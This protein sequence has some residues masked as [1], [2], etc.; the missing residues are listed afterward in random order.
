MT[1]AASVWSGVIP[2]HM[3]QRA[4]W[5][6]WADEPDTGQ[7]KVPFIIGSGAKAKSN[8]PSTWRSFAE[9]LKYHESPRP[10]RTGVGYVFAPDDGLT[11][12][13]FDNCL[14]EGGIVLKAWAKP[15]VTP[16]LGKTYVEVSPSGKGLHVFV[17][18]AGPETGKVVKV[19]DGQ[20]E[21]YTRGR[22]STV[23][24]NVYGAQVH[25]TFPTFSER[26]ENRG[27]GLLDEAQDAVDA[28][29]E[30]LHPKTRRDERQ[31][32]T[33]GREKSTRVDNRYLPSRNFEDRE[34]ICD[35]LDAI[36][37]D[38]DYDRWTKIGM[39]LSAEYERHGTGLALWQSWSARGEK[40]KSG[41]C[42]AKWKSFRRN[43]VNIGTLFHIAKECGWQPH[44]APRTARPRG[45]APGSSESGDREPGQ[46]SGTPPEMDFAALIDRVDSLPDPAI[47]GP[48][49]L[50]EP[51]V[52]ALLHALPP[53]KLDAFALKLRL[54]AGVRRGSIDD[55]LERARQTKTSEDG[56][57]EV[58]PEVLAEAEELLRDSKILDRFNESVRA[59]GHVGEERTARA[60]LLAVVTRKTD[61]PIHVV[62]KSASAA[63]KNHTVR[64]VTDHLPPED[65]KEISDM[66]PKAL[67]Y[68]GDL[69]GKVVVLVEQNA[70]DQAEY[71]IRI[72]MSEGKLTT[73]AP[74][75]DPETGQIRTVEYVIEAGCFVSTTTR[76][77]LNDENETRVLE[78]TLDESPE[79]TRRITNELGRR[80]AFPPTP[81]ERERRE[82]DLMVWR[83][84]LGLLEPVEVIVPQAPKLA[85]TF[86]VSR[87]RARRDFPRL[88]AI[89]KASAIL[90]QHQRGR[91]EHGRVV[92]DEADVAIGKTICSDLIAGI[93][94]RLRQLHD[95]LAERLGIGEIFTPMQAA[96]ALG[97]DVAPTRRNL[98]ALES[99]GLSEVVEEG[100]GRNPSKW[101]LLSDL[102]NL[103]DFSPK[104][105]KSAGAVGE[106]ACRT[107]EPGRRGIPRQETL[108]IPPG[109]IP[110]EQIWTPEELAAARALRAEGE[111]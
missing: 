35:A 85:E 19:G 58:D 57:P 87:I 24:G 12:I 29:L 26:S 44:R 93:S 64:A 84:A 109:G 45:D 1:A 28:L 47:D 111:S 94:P 16:F 3:Q 46:G 67:Q 97:H 71:S 65:V 88:L 21:I 10:E 9:A 42:E 30:A 102:S 76:A 107:D 40:Y 104:S 33:E 91:D 23:T 39:A 14:V 36:P 18:A 83:C 27:S 75:K 4:Q 108:D 51:A 61:A 43:G 56:P 74:S 89:T 62:V 63:G 7:K 8:D 73:W 79:Q 82:Q 96:A 38:I 77:A 37:P 6:R 41:E 15:L 68:G 80:T 55:V 5:V 13:D 66:S 2:A 78:L 17:I 90:H 60:L 34:R 101:K 110:P 48:A 20:V 69:K 72:A 70:G 49:L 25:E 59:G 106:T 50:E 98:K 52:V 22:Y 95:R 31:V 100:R 32:S 54:R 105:V 53:A 92:A 81:D 103:S 86:S 99:A 11:F